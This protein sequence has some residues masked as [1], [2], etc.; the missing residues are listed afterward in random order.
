MTETNQ[1]P[2][3]GSLRKVFLTVVAFAYLVTL[4]GAFVAFYW[5]A[6]SISDEYVERFALAQNELE[7]N[8]ILSLVDRE[9]ALSRKLADDPQVR[10][11][12]RDENDPELRAL[13]QRQIESYHRFLGYGTVFVA[14][15][16]SG[17]YYVSAGESPDLMQTV[18]DTN[19][20]DDRWF[21]EFLERN[22]D[23]SMNVNYDA[24]LDEVRVWM[25]VIVRDAD[26]APIGVAGSG[27]D[28]T[29]FL[30]N[31]V[32]HSEPGIRTIIV[33][34]AG[35]LQA[36]PDRSLIEHNARVV[37]DADKVTVFDL[38]DDSKSIG[39][40]RSAIAGNATGAKLFP[41]VMDGQT[42][43]TAV[44]SLTDLDWHNLVLV[45]AGTIIGPG[46][47]LPLGLVFLASLLAVLFCL[48]FLLNSLIIDPLQKLTRAAGSVAEGAHD[49]QIPEGGNNEIGELS[50]SFNTMTRKIRQYTSGLESMVKE[51][52]KALAA[53]NRDL[54]ASQKRITD[55]IQYARIIQNSILP[56]PQELDPHLAEYFVIL[57]P[58][59]PVGG[60]FHF[61]RETRD[62]FC[63]A[64]VDCTGHGVPGAFMTMMVNALLNRIIETAPDKGPAAVL[65]T[66]HVLVQETLR[67][68]ANGGQAVENG[69]DIAFCRVR[70]GDEVIDFAGAGLPL[71]VK[72][73]LGIREIPGDRRRLG[74]SSAHESR[75]FTEHRLALSPEQ[76][77]Y[78]T[79]D[80]VLDLPGGEKGF[81]LGRKRLTELLSQLAGRSLAEQE[82]H[83]R[84]AL[85]DYRG[86][87]PQRD[88]LLLCGFRVSLTKE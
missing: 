20:P 12:I 79:S 17:N 67:G 43:V 3:S 82:E 54:T 49:T 64:A 30:E 74:F 15:R 56:S 21:F 5:S 65:D 71:F 46:D 66:L 28:L 2:I 13:A 76:T 53:T 32:E 27:I 19:D 42:A 72:D 47:F 37:D 60:D 4:T 70:P 85:K 44:G 10:D 84:Q 59:D 62:G 23:Y 80:G 41:L 68:N 34:S 35:E 18:L 1:R 36:H 58:V 22:P 14:V 6:R 52:T 11:W 50:A 31:L 57:E 25:N 86:D 9:L 87:H 69:L 7:R 61:F 81:G 39:S 78:L 45:D 29:R 77:F 8:R 24:L 63:V 33:N 75:A 40:L 88:D 73:D 38:L 16:S 26:G 48:M 83:L 55:S 51:R